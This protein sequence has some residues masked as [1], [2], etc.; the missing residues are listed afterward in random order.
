[1]KKIYYI[2]FIVA[3]AGVLSFVSGCGEK[4]PAGMPKPVPCTIVVTQE[5]QPLADAV[6]SLEPT[7][8]GKWGAIGKTDESGKAIVFTMDRYQGAVPGKYRVA[9]NKSETEKPTGQVTSSADKSTSLAGYDLVE[10]KY[11]SK[12]TS[13]LEIEVVKGTLEYPVDA[14]K[15]VRIKMPVR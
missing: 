1:M 3:V 7:D 4:L 5:G 8:D 12:V 6:V 15:A 9:V 14:G 11:R 2:Q 10:E 13:P